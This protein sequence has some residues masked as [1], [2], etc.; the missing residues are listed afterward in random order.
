MNEH[1]MFVVQAKNDPEIAA[2]MFTEQE[3]LKL[4]ARLNYEIC[5]HPGGQNLTKLQATELAASKTLVRIQAGW[6]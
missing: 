2:G 1:E 4:L 3:I 5:G 6:Q